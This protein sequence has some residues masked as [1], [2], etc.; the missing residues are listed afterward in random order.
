M[1][2]DQSGQEVICSE[3]GNKVSDSAES[4]VHCG[5][6]FGSSLENEEDD[7]GV[8]DHTIRAIVYSLVYTPTSA[9]SIIELYKM[10]ETKRSIILTIWL[11]VS[12]IIAVV[13]G[14]TVALR[15]I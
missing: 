8:R 11:L 1:T 10:G 6:T 7:L 3:C 4:C 9:R 13:I 14:V 15:I 2:V 12:L 5:A